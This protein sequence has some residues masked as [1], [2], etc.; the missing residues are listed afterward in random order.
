MGWVWVE[1]DGSGLDGWGGVW[2]VGF[3]VGWG[4]GWGGVRVNL[5][6][7]EKKALREEDFFLEKA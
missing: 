7:W 2:D 1:E 6:I 4:C 5:G 3:G